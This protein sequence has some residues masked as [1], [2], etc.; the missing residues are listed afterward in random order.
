M[1]KN[2]L[3]I[4]Y[5]SVIKDKLYASINLF[6]LALGMA[7]CILI[8]AYIGYEL[9]FDAYHKNADSYL[10]DR[11]QENDDGKDQAACRHAGAGWAEDGPRLSRSPR[12]R[13]IRRY[14]QKSVPIP[15]QER[16]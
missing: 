4:T 10:P 3:K 8:L 15:G 1:F 16:F 5:R 2:V 11:I 12:R 6:G 13:P 7:G 9:S 14:G